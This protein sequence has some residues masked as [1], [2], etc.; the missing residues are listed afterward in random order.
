MTSPIERLPVEL[1]DLCAAHLQLPAYQALRLTSHKLYSLTLSAF[2]KTHFSTLTTTLG[3]PSLNHLLAIASR[4]YLASAVTVVDITLLNHHDYDIMSKI[5]R[6]GIFPPP[7][8]FPTLTCVKL[9]HIVQESTLYDDITGPDSKHL[10]QRLVRCLKAFSNLRVVRLRVQ[11][12]EPR[13]WRSSPIPEKDQLFRAKCFQLVIG[14]LID[15]AVKLDE[16]SLGKDKGRNSSSLTRCANL[17]YTALQLPAD[18]MRKLK[19]YFSSLE[20]MTLSTVASHNGPP[21]APGWAND[22]GRVVATAPLLERLVVSLDRKRQVSRY[23]A[24]VIRSLSLSVRLA[25]LKVLQL[26]NSTSHAEDLV[27]LIRTH[28]LSLRKLAFVRVCLLSGS[29]HSVLTLLYAVDGLQCLVLASVENAYA[30]VVFYLFSRHKKGRHS[31]V[32]DTS[33]ARCSMASMLDGLYIDCDTERQDLVTNA[34]EIQSPIP[35]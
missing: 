14:A 35:I 2:A 6:I 1:F 32:L 23:G 11:Q 34:G 7:K 33:L 24:P 17:P 4:K 21:R 22:L 9:E 27:R 5:R 26:H 16:F 10:S 15:S 8:R 13:E 3:A 12:S 31:V 29:W 19:T 30:P 25:K 18:C 28:R 20:S